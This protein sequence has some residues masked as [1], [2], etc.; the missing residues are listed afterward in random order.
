MWIIWG[1]CTTLT[2]PPEPACDMQWGQCRRLL[3]D[4]WTE[5]GL[6]REM[7]VSLAVKSYSFTLTFQYMLHMTT[8][9]SHES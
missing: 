2:S 1:V 9:E 4:N 7:N 8:Q 3:L 5:S 6:N